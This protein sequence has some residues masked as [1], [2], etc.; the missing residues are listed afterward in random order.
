MKQHLRG[1]SYVILALPIFVTISV[2]FV[3]YMVVV[4]GGHAL[5]GESSGF[6]GGE[7]EEDC[8]LGCPSSGR[9]IIALLMGAASTS[10]TSENVYQTTQK[11]A[12]SMSF[13]FV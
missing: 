10:E 1:H 9:S 4:M 11:T 7:Y 6:H 5:L 8:L 12:I 2:V 13:Y 3:S